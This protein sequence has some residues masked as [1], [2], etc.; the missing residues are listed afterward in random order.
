MKK[1]TRKLLTLSRDTLVRLGDRDL[2]AAVGGA[3]PTTNETI[4]C[5]RVQGSCLSCGPTHCP[6]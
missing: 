2:Q 6:G 5:S 1:K 3:P 4:R